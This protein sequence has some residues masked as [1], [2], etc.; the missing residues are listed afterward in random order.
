VSAWTP[1]TALTDDL[2]MTFSVRTTP[3]AVSRKNAAPES[4][5]LTGVV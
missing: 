2:G 4:D 5:A 1:A 3:P